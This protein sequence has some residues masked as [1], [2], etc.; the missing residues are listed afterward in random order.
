MKDLFSSYRCIFIGKYLNRSP[1]FQRCSTHTQFPLK[2]S[3]QYFDHQVTTAVKM[4]PIAVV[5]AAAQAGP[6][7]VQCPGLQW[8]Q[9]LSWNGTGGGQ[10]P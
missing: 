1:D 8:E 5:V 3:A 2:K 10:K 9:S 6:W 7:H 4:G